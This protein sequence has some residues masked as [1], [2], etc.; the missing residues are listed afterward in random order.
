MRRLTVL[1]VLGAP[2]VDPVEK[3]KHEIV[4][5]LSAI[6]ERE[7]RAHERRLFKALGLKKA[8]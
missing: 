7:L 1:D 5:E 8:K 2:P 3:L 6:I 4:V